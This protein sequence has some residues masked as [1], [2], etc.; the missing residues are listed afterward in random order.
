MLP[1]PAVLALATLV[2]LASSGCGRV[3]EI[4]ACRALA[5]EVNPVL[6]EV[7]ALSKLPGGGHQPTMANR[8]AELAARVKTRSQKGGTLATALAEYASIL[9]ATCLALRA[10]EEATRLNQPARITEK[11]RELE[12]L[13]KRERVSV[14]RID[15]ECQS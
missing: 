14:T 12:R 10:H 13:V 1:R 7:E 15:A 8:Y 2:L 3:R 9:E 11:R 4:S 6:S 5:R